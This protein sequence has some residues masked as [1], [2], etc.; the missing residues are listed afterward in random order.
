MRR[1]AHRRHLLFGQLRDAVEQ[2]ALLANTSDDDIGTFWHVTDWHVNEFQPA[3]PNPCDMCRSAS[4]PATRCEHPPAGPFG[5]QECDPAP[6][7]WR[8]ALAAMQRDLASSKAKHAAVVQQRSVAQAALA[9]IQAELEEER[10]LSVATRRSSVEASV[11]LERERAERRSDA[12]AHASKVRELEEANRD[13]MLFLETR[14]AVAD[15]G[16][17]GGDVMGVGEAPETEIDPSDRAAVM[18]ARLRKK[19][20]AKVGR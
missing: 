6:S 18:R 5:H 7:F 8:E 11:A 17:S 20:K 2:Q 12:E 14:D 19:Q 3:N 10:A 9:R 13:L 4:T 15:A 16:A 1:G